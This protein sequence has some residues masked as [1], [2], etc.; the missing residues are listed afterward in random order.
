MPA[1][2]IQLLGAEKA[3]FRH[4]KNK[5]KIKS[6]KYGLIFNHQFISSQ[7]KSNRGKAARVLADKLSLALKVDYFKGDFIADKLIGDLKIR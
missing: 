3:L 5:K 6:P 2:T 4:L 1:S 7:K